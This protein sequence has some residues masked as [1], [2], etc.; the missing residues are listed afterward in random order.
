M[1][2]KLVRLSDVETLIKNKIDNLWIRDY[3]DHTEVELEKLV[4]SLSLLPAQNEWIAVGEKMPKPMIKHIVYSSEGIGIWA[5]DDWTWY[6]EYLTQFYH[7]S[8]FMP[9]PLPPT[10]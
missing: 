6:N 8:H 5:Y 4:S 9:L 1:S 3:W 7:V 10:N 2:D